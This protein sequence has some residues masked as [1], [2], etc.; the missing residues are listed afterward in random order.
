MESKKI[1]LVSKTEFP[2]LLATD[3]EKATD[4]FG[5]NIGQAIQYE[6]FRQDSGN[7][8]FYDQAAEFHKLRLYARGEQPIQI[9]KDRF[10][11][12]GDMSKL[13]LDW[14][15]VPIAEKFVDIIVNGM[16]DRMLT[17]KAYAQDA[18]S[19]EKRDSYQQ[20]I[21]KD[22]IA[23]PFLEQTQEEFGI[24]AFNVPQENIPET[25]QEL[26]LHMQME[27]KPAIEIAEETAI[28]TVMD[29]NNFYEEIKPV[30][31]YDVTTIGIG[32][33]KHRYSFGEGIK[34]ENVD[35][36][37]FIRNYTED[38]FSKDMF[39]TGEV[40]RVPITE[41][42]KIKPS[43]TDIEIADIAKSNSAW[44][45]E[46]RT[47]DTH[48]NDLFQNNVVNV[49]YFQYKTDRKFIKK[50]KCF[51]NGGER[52]VDR[53]ESFV[54]PD[55]DEE[56]MF[57]RL[58]KKI[59]VWYTGAMILGTQIILEWGLAR[60]M[61]KPDSAFQRVKS[62][63]IIA[64]PRPYKGR[65]R[66]IVQRM[67]SNIDM[68]QLT[69]LKLQQVQSKVVPDG[70]YLDADGLADI[71]LGNG[72][73]YGP[74]EAM[75]MYFTTGSVIGRSYTGD[76]EYNQA[77]IPIQELTHSS[78]QTKMQ[79]LIMSYNHYL[80]GIRDFTGLNQARDAS[81]P[82]KDALVGLQKL[83]ALSS[84]VA[85][86]HILDAGKWMIK[87]LAE[88]L[89]IRISDVLEY[90]DD[91][92]EFANQIGKYNVA[93]LDNIKDLYLSSF[94]IFVEVSPDEEQRA[95]LERDIAIALK[96]QTISLSDAM[97][98]RDQQN[99]KVANQLLKLKEKQKRKRDSEA[100]EMEMQ[101]QAAINNQ[102]SASAAENAMKK[103]QAE[104]QAE[105]AI[106]NSKIQ[107]DLQKLS[108][109]VQA[110]TRLMEIEH[111]YNMELARVT[112]SELQKRDDNKEKAKDN[113]LN[114]Q[115]TQQ[116]ALVAQR[117]NGSLPTDFET[118]NEP[119][120]VGDLGLSPFTPK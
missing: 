112:S 9:Y 21:E 110:K 73:K 90:S 94:G 30:F 71:N 12:N 43:L 33:V 60:N 87:E 86:K 42:R 26:Q 62:E 63:Y 46:Y 45:E 2:D 117:Q 77:K 85:T 75:N 96:E 14:N 109:E 8:R 4:A 119:D 113:R 74:T 44:N 107:G 59:E 15:I 48:R 88:C 49:L 92:E 3:A 40:K 38:R 78:G 51:E 57:E 102:S 47:G 53:D 37:N 69:H 39:Y 10:A 23:K 111:N 55:T 120:I 95:N 82:N 99:I 76:G 17:P 25:D 64:T 114:T 105:I 116:G 89:T 97:D 80:D 100:R 18:S 70:V 108:F 19:A 35:P 50:V 61:V 28:S 36:A 72:A 79:S 91:K 22:M 93:M 106:N 56:V 84:N 104:A 115:S 118:N 7:C 16:S 11:G 65:W 31:D 66:S 58:E 83:A 6:W 81:T 41:L 101:Q 24:N 67:V 103:I 34:I 54:M 27:Y 98:I 1:V 5:L 20:N 29:M 32:I 13:N 52:L 68:I